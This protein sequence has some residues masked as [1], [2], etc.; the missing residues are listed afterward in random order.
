MKETKKQIKAQLTNEIANRYKA[1]ILNL[2]S[3][4]MGFRAKYEEERKRRISAESQLSELQEKVEQYEDWVRRLQEFMD[5]EPDA[6][7]KAIADLKVRYEIS[8][9]MKGVMDFYS[10]FMFL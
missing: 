2:K 7:D 3:D 10:R 1:E 4:V 6:R 8:Q 9:K 5:M